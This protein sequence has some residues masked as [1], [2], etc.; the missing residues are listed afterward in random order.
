MIGAW[1]FS[2]HLQIY[3]LNFIFHLPISYRFS[4]YPY[5]PL[6]PIHPFIKCGMTSRVK[7]FSK[8]THF[9]NLRYPPVL[10][11]L[12]TTIK[13]KEAWERD[14]GLTFMRIGRTLLLLT[15]T[16]ARFVPVSLSFTLKYCSGFIFW[17]LDYDEYFLR[18]QIAVINVRDYF[19]LTQM[20]FSCPC[21]VNFWHH[22][23]NTMSKILSI[24]YYGFFSLL[25][26]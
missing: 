5:F 12:N 25:W 3:W 13:I 16:G 26:F 15:F 2:A 11:Q 6:F 9:K 14:L 1:G 23:G 24:S 10:W 22:Y 21:L 19:H 4:T 17:K 20:F 7:P 18:L 8:I